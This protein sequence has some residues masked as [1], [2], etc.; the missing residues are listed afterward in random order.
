MP[1]NSPDRELP[2]AL[3]DRGDDTGAGQLEVDAGYSYMELSG[4][5]AG[6]FDLDEHRK[7]LRKMTRRLKDPVR[8]SETFKASASGMMAVVR[9]QGLEGVVA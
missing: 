2:K 5:A 9:E 1:R 3:H 7:A 4:R 8:F 6:G